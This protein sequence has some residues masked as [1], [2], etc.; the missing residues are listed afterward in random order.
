MIDKL[1]SFSIHNKLIVGLFVLA[2]IGWGI[3]SMRQIPIDAVPDIT[4]NQVQIITQSPTL[5]AQEVE[6]FV[7]FP[8]E[9]TMANLPDIEEIRSVSRFGISVVTIV[10]KDDVDIYHA[11]QLISE[12]LKI[13]EGEIPKGFGNPELGPITTGLGEVYQYVLHT[14]PGYDTLYTDMD[15]RTINDWIVK[16]QLAGTPGVIEVSGWGGHLKQYEVAVNP[17]RLNSM[18]ISIA[19][20]FTALEANNENTGG[21]YIENR[22]NTYFIRGEGL[23]TSLTDIENTVVK[24]VN[25]IPILIRDIAE[26]GYGSAPRYGALTWNGKG[27]VV[28]GQTLMLKGANA[29]EVMEAVKERIT[30]IKKSL[31]E[32]I[33]LE[34]FIDRSHLIDR[35]MNT[36]TT[37]L[38]EGGLIVILILVLLLGNLR[39]GLIVASV[40]PLAMLFTMG[41]MNLFDV[42]ANLMSLGPIDFGLVVD[43]SVIIV[44]AILYRLHS[45]FNGQTLTSKSMDKEVNSAASKI[46]SSAAFGEIIILIVYLPILALVGIEGKMFKPMAQ[47]VSFAIIGALL[48]SLTYVPMMSALFLKK[49]IRKHRTFSDRLIN[50]LQAVY[51]PLIAIA[52][53][54]KS[55]VIVAALFLFGMSLFTFNRLGGEFI[56]TLEEGDFALHQILPPGSSL[57]QSVEVSKKIQEVLLNEFPE[58]E[59]VVSKIGTSEIPTDPMPIEVGDIMVHMRPKNEWVSAQSKEEM[60]EKMEVA[61]AVIPGVQYEFTQPIQMRFNELIAGVREDIAIKLFGENTEVLFQ[62]A[63]KAEKII[64]GI[65]GVGD[66]RLEQTQGLPQ[67]I[68]R[69]EREKIAQYGL[70]IKDLNTTLRTA[71]AGE[72]AGVV[73]EEEKRFDLV[74]RLQKTYRQDIENIRNL[75]IPLPNGSQIPLKEVATIRLENGPMQISR[76]DAKR[77]IV[78]GVNA[79]NR[80]TES[81]VNEIKQTLDEQLNLP[82]GYTIRYGGQFANLIAA[83]KRLAIAVPVALLLILTL[84]YFTFRSINQALLIFTAIPLSAIGGIYALWIRDMAF[85]ISAG[86]GFIALFGVAVLNGIVLI[87]YFNQLKKEGIADVNERIVLGTRVRLRPV[88]MTA[89]VAAFGFLPMALSTSAGAEVQRPLATVVIGGLITATLLTLF[90]LPVLYALLDRFSR[91]KGT[92]KNVMFCLLLVC[93]TPRLIAQP[94][95]ALTLEEAISL[96]QQNHP[97]VKQAALEVEKQIKLKK[98]TFDLG[99]TNLNYTNGQINSAAIDYHW[100]LNQQIKFP[101][102]YLTQAQLQ[103]QQ[104]AL[105]EIALMVSQLAI[106][107]NVRLAWWQ[108]TYGTAK[109]MLIDELADYYAAFAQ[110]AAKRYEAGAINMLEKLRAQA[111]YEQLRLQQNEC[112]IDEEVYTKALARWLGKDTA[113][114]IDAESLNAPSSLNLTNQPTLSENPQLKYQNQLQEVARWKHKSTRAAFLPGLSLG[115]FN[116]R[117]DGTEDLEGLLFGIQLPLFFWTQS[118]NVQAARL[119]REQ[120]A[121]NYHHQLLELQ[122]GQIN[123]QAQLTKLIAQ[124]EWY[125]TQGLPTA[126]AL[127]RFTNKAYLRGELSYI[128]YINNVDEA[129]KLK[130]NFLDLLLNFRQTQTELSY[131]YGRFE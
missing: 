102:T 120:T 89:A 13:A 53:R 95:E 70:K 22:Y 26:V 126:E 73:F 34:A 83:K 35:A 66:L 58:V 31:P 75:F 37:N 100:Q 11:R 121:Q 118:G 129:M 56:P 74:V 2:L 80:D 50:R 92:V 62:Y 71:F 54:R 77:R 105:S 52:L 97:L 4:T 109:R 106:E 112:K 94:M 64:K 108:L 127:L 16:R 122:T 6:Q 39:G 99:T 90:V 107:R 116:Q 130:L 59:T 30:S 131:L 68:V 85:S 55:M 51:E 42:S 114:A 27:E 128:E 103:K 104:V 69:Y 111:Q 81:L 41:M 76:E 28:G 3:I 10:F 20:V 21:S 110:V 98:T 63:Q 101:T 78:I 8:I 72:T 96:A 113:F 23:V 84:L 93:W 60:F 115:Y 44:E 45:K 24:T 46:R 82:A 119:E 18:N 40:I 79:R 57:E 43:G 49:E 47:T 32:G 19:E 117:I 86:I 65:D 88:I 91:R 124:I 1:I 5:A 123:T 125:E 67:M 7:T 61:L 12:Q 87:A 29:Y 25:N 9:I 48:L 15:L 14:L 33:E 38:I 36:V 17:E